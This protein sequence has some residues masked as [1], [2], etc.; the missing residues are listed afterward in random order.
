MPG[1]PRV[2]TASRTTDVIDLT[3]EPDSPVQTRS[4][5]SRQ[6]SLSTSQST[7]QG[8]RNPRRTSSLRTITPPRLARSDGVFM[9]PSPER[10]IDLTSDSPEAE[11]ETPGERFRAA[12]A[13]AARE[14]HERSMRAQFG[15]LGWTHPPNLEDHLVQLNVEPSW[16]TPAHGPGHWTRMMPSGMAST[17]QQM[18]TNAMPSF[19][20]GLASSF[21]QPD[22]DVTGSARVTKPPLPPPPPTRAGFTRDTCE[23]TDDVA[24]CP[25]CDGEL[26]YD[27]L[28]VDAPATSSPR[29]RK[30]TVAQHH[31]WA[32]KACGHVSQPLLTVHSHPDEIFQLYCANCFDNRRP[33]QGRDNPNF[34]RG[35]STSDLRCAVE[36]CDTRVNA[37]A[38]WVGI[39]L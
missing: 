28:A 24:I 4:S 34:R 36:G 16:N 12:A 35:T 7:S 14:L 39:F 38:D 15:N 18:L 8:F 32:V 20:R 10:V 9:A 37:K 19:P 31:F 11:A 23:E 33:K 13:A 26:A 22:L 2:Q 3:A 17:L 25:A 1:H 5:V 6:H 27:P 29:K 30:R 21:G